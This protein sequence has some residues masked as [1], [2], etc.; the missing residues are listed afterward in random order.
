MAER[1]GVR[2]VVLDYLAISKPRVFL[3]LVVVA[4]AAM[5]LAAE[6]T[7]D[8]AAFAEVTL[9]G[10]ASTASAGAFNSVIE[11][12]RD[13]L[14]GR[15]ANRPIPAGRISVG[16]GLAYASVMA[17]ASFAALAVPGHL[18]AAMLTLGAIAYYVV[19][20]T[21]L[22]KPTT[23]QSI[24]IGGLAGSFP[25]VIGWA[26]VTHSLAWPAAWPAFLLALLVFVW[27]PAHFWALALLYKDDYAAAG[28][29]M[30]P[31]VR[32]EG[33]ALR[34]ILAY[35]GLTLASSLVLVVFDAAGWLYL[36]V[37]AV[38]GLVLVGR[39]A[40]LLRSP[41]PP[42]Y[43][44]F[45]FFSIQYLGLLLLALMADLTLGLAPLQG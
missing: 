29:P 12:K 43:R 10:F 45:F 18:L 19:V 27:T 9:A 24:V 26:A 3:L 28:V 41:S 38:L 25:A 32:G 34:A 4:W 42:R 30:L 44:S 1:R 2:S 36:A 21:V 39:A 20:Y 31:N 35:S 33:A 40:S 5:F 6:G 23:P 11:R 16:A 15:T 8:G 17:A 22:L 37:A 7:P 14:M 13:G